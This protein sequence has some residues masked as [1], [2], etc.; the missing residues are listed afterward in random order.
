M[1]GARR[2]L[3][4]AVLVLPLTGCAERG[5]ASGPSSP[6][7]LTTWTAVVVAATAAALVLAALVVLPRRPSGGS[8]LAAGFLALE[9]GA[10]VVGGAALLGVAVR[11]QALVTRG[12]DAE[13]A[14]SLL[15]LS[16]LDGRDTGFFNLMAVLIATVGA[17]LVAVLVLAARAA[18]DGDPV[19]RLLASAVLVVETGLCVAA[20]VL[21]IVGFRGLPYTIPAAALPLVALVTVASWPR[22][23]RH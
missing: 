3:G 1:T 2:W 19:D 13:Q 20:G 12:A 17:L 11:S 5:L 10:A 16:G 18:A 9:A 22:P 7:S 21:V 6:A 14:A 23:A 15:R 4:G 8:I